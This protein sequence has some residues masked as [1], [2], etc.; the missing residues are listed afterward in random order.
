M[1][2][3]R[4]HWRRLR[5]HRPEGP[6]SSMTWPVIALRRPVILLA[7]RPDL[8]PPEAVTPTLIHARRMNQW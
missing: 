4:H 5:Q 2:V 6:S 1:A 7:R 3:V 8:C